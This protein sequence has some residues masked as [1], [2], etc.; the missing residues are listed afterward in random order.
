M[1]YDERPLG[2]GLYTV[3]YSKRHPETRKPVGLR[4]IK[5]KGLAKARRVHEELIVKVNDKIR[6]QGK[7]TWQETL[8][9]Y[10]VTKESEDWAKST[11]D[12]IKL[13]L[14]AHTRQWQEDLITDL[15]S[16]EVKELLFSEPIASKSA[17]YRQYLLKALKG[18]FQFALDNGF[19]DRNPV[20]RISFRFGQKQKKFLTE[21]QVKMFLAK[22]KEF[23][24]PWYYHWL[25]AVYTG[26]RNGELYA[27]TWDKVDLDR[28]VLT[29]D[30]S[31]TKQGGFKSTK[32]GDDRIVEIAPA[33][34]IE[35]KALKLEFP[36]H[37]VLP[38]SRDWDKGE[39]ARQLRMFLEGIGL[40][41]IR[42]HDLR[43]TWAT[44]ML[45][46][47]IE[48]IKVMKMGGWTQLKTMQIYIRSA[49]IDIRGIT[50][51]LLLH[52]NQ[53]NSGKI[54]KFEGP[55]SNL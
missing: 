16:R 1:G 35:L 47:G 54:L 31:W 26:L 42:F 28:R 36:G 5:V 43:A 38:R 17:H 25:L 6:K 50:D 34:L 21:P 41:I 29:V 15:G 46:K 8:Q 19:I 2:S 12:S 55:G 53:A 48:P 51:D 18:V 9:D 4:R 32:S 49:G 52:E 44:I 11:V 30:Q 23:D 13:C 37:F 3:W 14:N 10:L 20:P 45:S 40:P 22:A 27:L 33:L 24:S 39:Q 7:P